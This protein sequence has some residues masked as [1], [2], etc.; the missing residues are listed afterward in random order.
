[1]A[2][3]ALLPDL[4]SLN[5][6]E[7]E[8]LALLAQGHTAKSIANLTGR[9]EGS[10]N[11]RLREARRK[12]GVASSRELAR[13]LAEAPSPKNRDEQ[14]GMAC[15]AAGEPEA[16]SNATPLRG[17]RLG[18][19]AIGMTFVSGAAI[20]G[21]ALFSIQAPQTAVPEADPVLGN[22]FATAQSPSLADLHREVRSEA[23]DT[24]WAAAT[25]AAINAQFMKHAGLG[26]SGD[27]L[28]VTCG[29]TLCEVALTMTPGNE[30][31]VASVM[32]EIQKVPLQDAMRALDVT[33]EIMSFG[34][35]D[36]Q[37]AKPLHVSYW[38]R[39]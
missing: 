17:G 14:I 11:E 13:L 29:K 12:T 26:H 36:D 25:E 39:K 7:R 10:V 15:R 9:T 38:R 37:P 3:S 21:I 4:S 22:S 19:G 28:R 35:S 27:V 18:K 6:A 33:S 1:M 32:N 23:R 2:A 20:F 5:P 16:P 30:R 31:R 24:N 8:V 34:R